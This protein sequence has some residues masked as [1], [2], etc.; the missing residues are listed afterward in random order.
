MPAD[1]RVAIAQKAIAAEPRNP[2]ALTALAGAYLQ[3]TRETTDFSYVERAAKLV[4]QALTLRPEDAEAALLWN[5]LEMHRHHFAKVVD[6]T[7]RL[8]ANAPADARLWALQGDALMELGGYDGAA[9]AYE[10]MLTLRPGFSS[11][12]RVAWFRFVT[13]DA[14]GAIEAMRQAVRSARVSP[15]NLAWCLVDLGNLYFK[16]G[17][18]AEAEASYN[19]AL[20]AFARYHA[21]QAGLGKVYAERGDKAAAVVQFSRAQ[22]AVPLAEYSGAL[23]DL[24]LAQGYKAKAREQEALLDAVDRL[25]RAQFENTDRTLALV[26]ADQG[27]KL[28]RAL[29]LARNELAFRKDV[30]TYDALAWV[31]YRLGRMDEAKEAMQKALAQGTPEPMFR[32]HAEMLGLGR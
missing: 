1:E 32:R 23:R 26:Y 10:R 19:T 8:L 16:T 17:R 9:A 5:E 28:D 29:E 25:A 30:Y 20:S 22:Q 15:E 18:L 27:R 3:K 21:A 11:Y 31:L 13:G 7:T 14:E 6:N 24:Y 2:S 12:N 4:Q